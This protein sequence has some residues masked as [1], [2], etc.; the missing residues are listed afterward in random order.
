MLPMQGAGVQSLIGELRSHARSKP[1][2]CTKDPVQPKY[3]IIIIIIIKQKR[4][5]Q[6]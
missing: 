2:H 6:S 5:Y 4:M 3:I 1:A